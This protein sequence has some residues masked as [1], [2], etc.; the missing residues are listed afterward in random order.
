[1]PKTSRY[2]TAMAR[3]RHQFARHSLDRVGSLAEV[4]QRA[5]VASG[6]SVTVTHTEELFDNFGSALTYNFTDRSVIVLRKQD[7]AFYRTRGLF[8]EVAHLLFGHPGC[9]VLQAAFD[10]SPP[11]DLPTVVRVDVN[12]LYA[13]D[14]EELEAEALAIL[15][16]R[17]VL[18]P[19]H[20]FDERI[21]G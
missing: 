5:A 3:A 12:A 21:F 10:G 13:N 18:R 4:V 11:P 7:E 15:I 9:K 2:A 19:K 17:H 20:D 1:M 14:P 8:H 6:R 16:S